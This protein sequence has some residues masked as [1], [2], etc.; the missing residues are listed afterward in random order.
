MGIQRENQS[1]WTGTS[2]S[3]DCLHLLWEKQSI[4]LCV[5]SWAVSGCDVIMPQSNVTQQPGVI[6]I[7]SCNT[8]MQVQ[9]TSTFVWWVSRTRLCAAKCS[10]VTTSCL[11]SSGI[12][13]FTSIIWA[14]AV[15]CSARCKGLPIKFHISCCSAHKLPNVHLSFFSHFILSFCCQAPLQTLSTRKFKVSRLTSFKV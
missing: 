4:S 3:F 10:L 12:S 9:S 7:T 1:T 6:L 14:T 5:D 8:I 15:Q 11:A 2:L 13:D